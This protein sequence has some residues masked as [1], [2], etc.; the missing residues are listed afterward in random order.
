MLTMVAMQIIHTFLDF[1]NSNIESLTIAFGL[2]EQSISRANYTL[3]LEGLTHV[4][5]S[6][7]SS[8]KLKKCDLQHFLRKVL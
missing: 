1:H 6:R 4:A 7:V 3:W 2:M 5:P 8:L